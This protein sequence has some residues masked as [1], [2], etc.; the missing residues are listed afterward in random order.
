MLFGQ[1]IGTIVALGPN[2]FF[3]GLHVHA[4]FLSPDPGDDSGI[5]MPDNSPSRAWLKL[6]S[7]YS[8]CAYDTKTY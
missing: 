8:Q 3:A 7:G 4:P 2:E 6:G 1:V 5:I